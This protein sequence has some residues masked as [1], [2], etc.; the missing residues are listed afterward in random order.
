MYHC[1][2]ADS[3]HTVT[4]LQVCGLGAIDLPM[5]L[6]CVMDLGLY[7]VNSNVLRAM[8]SQTV[9]FSDLIP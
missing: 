1:Y 6:R 3:I 8:K 7:K 4:G 5:W 2:D 9:Y